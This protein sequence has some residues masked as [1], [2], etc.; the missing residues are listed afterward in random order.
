MHWTTAEETHSGLREAAVAQRWLN[1]LPRVEQ[2]SINRN[3]HAKVALF[4]AVNADFGFA[5]QL[6]DDGYHSSLQWPLYLNDCRPLVRANDDIVELLT[7]QG[8]VTTD[9]VKRFGVTTQ[10]TQ[11]V[12]LEGSQ[13]STQISP[14]DHTET[15]QPRYLL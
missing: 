1:F 3:S 15:T 13:D 11:S 14:E 2:Y 4:F 9:L 5:K 7:S 10:E 12:S 8:I 6:L